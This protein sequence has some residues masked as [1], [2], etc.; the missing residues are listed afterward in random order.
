MMLK[1]IVGIFIFVQYL[2]LHP[3]CQ[4]STKLIQYINWIPK[5][6]TLIEVING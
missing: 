4:I 1:I 2:G 6:K 5:D 3:V